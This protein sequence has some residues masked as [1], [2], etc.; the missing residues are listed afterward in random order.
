L[1]GS[2]RTL[3]VDTDTEGNKL[4]SLQS[5]P[6]KSENQIMSCSTEATSQQ[7]EAQVIPECK[8]GE[9]LIDGIA[10][11]NPENMEIL[12]KKY[13][14]RIV[15][16]KTCDDGEWRIVNIRVDRM[17]PL[18][19]LSSLIKDIS[20][21]DE[22]NFILSKV[23]NGCDFEV[24]NFSSRLNSLAPLDE[25]KCVLGHRLQKGEGRVSIYFLQMDHQ[26]LAPVYLKDVVLHESMATGQIK[27]LISQEIKAMSLCIDTTK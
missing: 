12:K 23:Y 21:V 20:G 17:I 2:D 25:I 18:A 24:V 15:A 13:Y 10:D 11:A 19:V 14:F 8:I 1:T 6:T 27:D 5:S 26:P 22:K 4:S 9:I 3:V 7:S 16:D